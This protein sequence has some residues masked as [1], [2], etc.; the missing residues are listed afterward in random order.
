M[1]WTFINFLAAIVYSCNIQTTEL[2]YDAEV[3][4]QTVNL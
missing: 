1:A 4:K 2:A 3:K